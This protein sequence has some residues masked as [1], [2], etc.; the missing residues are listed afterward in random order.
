MFAF[1]LTIHIIV[2]CI[3]ILVILLQAGKGGDM[4][5]MFGGGGSQ[6]AF[7]GSGASTVLTKA[8]AIAA[9]IFM[10]TSLGLSAT[11][12]GKSSIIKE[13]TLAPVSV[14]PVAPPAKPAPPAPPATPGGQAAQPPAP[15]P[16]QPA[17]NQPPAP[18][19]T[20]V[21][22]PPVAATV[23]PPQTQPKATNR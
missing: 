4:G 15:A 17:P 12:G 13:E 7:G 10:I 21:P 14:Q 3:L 8:T 22:A 20:A 1:F 9:G 5:A 18:S 6:S 23:Q 19:G 16:F 11:S 2:S